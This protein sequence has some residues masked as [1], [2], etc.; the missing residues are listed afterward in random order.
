MNRIFQF[1]LALF[2]FF[3]W[4]AAQ[5]VKAQ[6]FEQ[7][8][9][10]ISPGIN[11]GGIGFY[12]SGAGLPIVA[13]GEYGILDMIGVGPYVG[14]VNYK[15]GSGS[16]SYSYRFITIGARGDFHYTALLEELLEADLLSD[17]LDL[18]LA[19][20]IGYQTVSYSGADGSF[21]RGL[22]SN[23]VNSGLAI[24]GR[25]YISPNLAVFVEAG[26]VLY[27]AL[28]IGVTLKIK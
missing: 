1:S 28:N 24:G 22:Y 2:F 16:S 19:V 8:H 5:N 11:L 12:G 14:F 3:S 6:S 27:G 25:Y 9:M 13:S 15:F 18:Y 17:K 4:S 26:R 10:G 23:R 7:G 21:F 20:L